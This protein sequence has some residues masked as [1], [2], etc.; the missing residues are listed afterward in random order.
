LT[1]LAGDIATRAKRQI[2]ELSGAAYRKTN[3]ITYKPSDLFGPSRL[4][5][6]TPEEEAQAIRD[7]Q[8]KREQE[9]Y[10]GVPD[11]LGAQNA[12][13][14]A[15]LRAAG[16]SK[17]SSPLALDAAKWAVDTGKTTLSADDIQT[18]FK[19]TQPE[20]A[21]VWQELRARGV[22]D[23]VGDIIPAAPAPAAPAPAGGEP[24]R[25]TPEAAQAALDSANAKAQGAPRVEPAPAPAAA[26]IE[27]TLPSDLAGA[28]PNYGYRGENYKL[29]FAS[30]YDRAAY[31]LANDAK[32][33]KSKAADRYEKALKAAGLD[34]AEAVAHGR[35]VRD[36]VKGMA[37]DFYDSPDGAGEIN[38]P[39]MG[40][41]QTAAGGAGG[42]L[43]PKPPG[44]PPPAE[45]PDP[46]SIDPDAQT[47]ENIALQESSLH[48]EGD[49]EAPRFE[50][51]AK[52]AHTEQQ[53][54]LEA[55]RKAVEDYASKPLPEGAL[56]PEAQA[57]IFRAEDE[58]IKL[59]LDFRRGQD[60]RAEFDQLHPARL[61][62]E[63]WVRHMALGH[64][65]VLLLGHPPG[66]QLRPPVDAE[67]GLPHRLPA[68]QAGS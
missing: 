30:D 10:A 68:L 23:A 1:R 22:I 48:N 5:A 3:D 13:G 57:A 58:T 17:P 16:A 60:L 14:L 11:A 31:I 8:A 38:V 56:S 33:G 32:S 39:D 45:P 64:R 24:M 42:R 67:P 18:Q 9:R 40:A 15:D 50:D 55:F 20:A 37:S 66:P 6:R 65:P 59:Q 35:K 61:R 49:H 7:T 43:P 54:A 21:Q 26:P 28:K 47:P 27:F 52:A 63:A 53:A 12:K 19:I 29:T 2:A 36:A 25:V 62:S 41:P 34:P 4:A 51:M 46:M 44:P